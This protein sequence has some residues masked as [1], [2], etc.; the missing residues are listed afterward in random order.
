VRGFKL[1]SG[2]LS[3]TMAHGAHKVVVGVAE[4]DIMAAIRELERMHG[5]LVAVSDG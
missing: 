5:G 1:H 2:A 4:S 3:S